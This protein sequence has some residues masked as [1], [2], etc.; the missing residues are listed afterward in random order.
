MDSVLDVCNRRCAGYVSIDH[1]RVGGVL[2]GL[3]QAGRW[4]TS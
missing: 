2:R 1:L 4:S 3:Q